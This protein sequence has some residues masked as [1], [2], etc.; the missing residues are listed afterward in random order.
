MISWPTVLDIRTSGWIILVRLLVGLVVCFPE[1][2][3]KLVFPEIL[4]AGR[5]AR[6]G[7]P[8]PEFTRAQR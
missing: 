5:F 7:I 6:I 4:G 2:I 8:N 1:G 3:R